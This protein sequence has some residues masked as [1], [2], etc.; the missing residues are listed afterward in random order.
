MAAASYIRINSYLPSCRI[1]TKTTPTKI[2]Y[3][4]EEVDGSSVAKPAPYIDVVH[5]TLEV[6][7]FQ[8]S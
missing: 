5:D 8:E 2:P 6:L 1:P 4:G 7:I 3:V